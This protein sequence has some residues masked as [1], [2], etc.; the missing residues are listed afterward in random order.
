MTV[1]T[2]ALQIIQSMSENQNDPQFINVVENWIRDALGEINLATRWHFA[3][4]TTTFNTVGG[5]ASY[6]LPIG[7]NDI[8]MLRLTNPRQV[9]EY[10]ENPM[11]LASRGFNFDIQAIP[12]FWTYEDSVI[13]GT[14]Q[15]FKIRIFPTPNA[16]Y[17]IERYGL[18][19]ADTL[20]SSDNIPLPGDLFTLVKDRV[21]AYLLEDD[22]DYTGHDRAYRRYQEGLEKAINK[23][24]TTISNFATVLQVSDMPRRREP[25]ARLDPFHF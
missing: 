8:Q 5:T 25:L 1:N 7:L 10:I 9:I 6:N 3:R 22:K 17:T 24:N 16:V 2:L 23:L 13:S 14:D 18:Y 19:N 4:S 20:S 12:R 15:V 21:R 11:V